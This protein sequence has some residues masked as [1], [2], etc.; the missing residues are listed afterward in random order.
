LSLHSSL[1]EIWQLFKEPVLAYFYYEKI[2]NDEFIIVDKPF[3]LIDFNLYI[4]KER[5]SE[6]KDVVTTLIALPKLIMFLKL[7]V[8]Y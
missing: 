8:Y 3:T 4:F 1:F 7:L 5:L 6:F 2:Y